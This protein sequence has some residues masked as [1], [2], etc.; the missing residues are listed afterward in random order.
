[1]KNHLAMML[2]AMEQARSVET[3]D[4]VKAASVRLSDALQPAGTSLYE[5]QN[6]QQ[7]EQAQNSSD[8]DDNVIDADFEESE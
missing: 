5:Q 7:E 2:S 6:Q 1:M 4:D 8:S 3:Y